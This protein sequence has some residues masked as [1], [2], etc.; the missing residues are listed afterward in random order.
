MHQGMTSSDVLDT[1]SRRAAPPARRTL[2]IAMSNAVLAALKARAM[3]HRRTP[4][5]GRSHGIHAEPTTF[6]LS[7]RALRGI[8]PAGRRAAGGRAG[9][10]R[11]LRHSG[12]SAPSASVDP[13]VEAFVAA[14]LGLAVEPVSTQVIPREPPR[15]AAFFCAL[16]V[17]ALRHRA[18]GDRGAA[19]AA[20]RE[21]RGGGVLPPGQKGSSAMPRTSAQSG[22]SENLTASPG[23]CAATPRRRWRMSRC[24]TNGTSAIPPWSG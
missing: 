11:D 13:R 12:R 8:P 14:K 1:C 23:W 17:V 15:H 5:V 21:A 6:G 10:D 7:S 9:R 19:F 24:G 22:L 18:A 3:E 20:V 4:T 16:A 2:L